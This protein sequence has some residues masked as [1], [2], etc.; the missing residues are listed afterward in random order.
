MNLFSD[1]PG[2]YPDGFLQVFAKG[3]TTGEFQI[4]YKPRGA[5]MVHFTLI[6]GGAGG[7]GGKTGAAGT[8]RGGGGGGGSGGMNRFSIAADLLPDILYI[9]VGLGG[10]GAAAD[11]TGTSGGIS[12]VCFAPSI[13]SNSNILHKSCN[14]AST[15]GSPGTAAA[16]G[17]GGAGGTSVNYGF[18]APWAS[19]VQGTGVA[20]Q[21]GANGGAHTGANGS[22]ITWATAGL[23]ITGG[24]GG[25]GTPTGNTDFSGGAINGSG[26]ILPTLAG[27]ASAAGRGNDGLFTRRPYFMSCGGSGGGT[28]GAAGTAGAGG[29]GGPGSG[30]GG[31]GGGVTGGA[32]GR[33]GDGLII[34][35]CS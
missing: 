24:S 28:A 35:T 15:G 6:G 33:G 30:G 25:G 23:I 31:G 29:D 7:G 20:G 1:F 18:G 27:G 12:Y 11:G 13:S 8:A 26:L 14:A 32:G 4:W 21:T 16:G 22:N 2:V 9:Q 34:I 17:N 10:P 3:C 19:L 5:K